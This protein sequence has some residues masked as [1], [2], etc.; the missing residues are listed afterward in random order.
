MGRDDRGC[1]LLVM[2]TLLITALFFRSLIE[3]EECL[4]LALVA[5]VVSLKR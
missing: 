3:R 2:A 4:G 1:Y 5:G